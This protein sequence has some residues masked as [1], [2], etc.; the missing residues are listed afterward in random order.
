MMQPLR[1]VTE[2]VS[3]TDVERYRFLYVNPAW[4]KLYGYSARQVLGKDVAPLINL[5]DIPPGVLQDIRIQTRKGNWEG[6]L[7]NRNK[8]GDEF[9]VNLRTAC[10]TDSDSKPLG[11]IGVAT[12]FD[13]EV[14]NG[15][16][17]FPKNS[18]TQWESKKKSVSE[19]LGQL[20]PR[21]LEI[22]TLFGQ[23]LTTRQVAEK[24]GISVYTVQT[25]RN[26]LKKKL[27][28][29]NCTELNLMAFKS[30]G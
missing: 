1:F 8:N 18:K 16:V 13:D 24:L 6:R 2:A 4:V 29:V 20:T 12:V 21:E 22:F 14:T 25:H 19:E 5:P 7:V 3:L 28:A 15:K 26:H 17:A 10:L 9:T 11:M 27:G 30:I 23:G